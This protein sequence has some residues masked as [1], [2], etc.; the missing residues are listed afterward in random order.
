MGIQGKGKEVI[1][2][3]VGLGYSRLPKPFLDQRRQGGMGK[4]LEEVM[5]EYRSAF[6]SSV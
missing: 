3:S 5:T 2:Q 1:D 6:S 4:R